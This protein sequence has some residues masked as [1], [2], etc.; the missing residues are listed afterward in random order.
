MDQQLSNS[1]TPVSPNDQE[2][3][4]PP[5]E[6]TRRGY[7]SQPQISQLLEQ[8]RDSRGDYRSLRHEIWGLAPA[9]PRVAEE[10]WVISI[11]AWAGLTEEESPSWTKQNPGARFLE[12]LIPDGTN[13]QRAKLIFERWVTVPNAYSAPWN[14]SFAVDS[15]DMMYQTTGENLREMFNSSDKI[16]GIIAQFSVSR[17]FDIIDL[18][19]AAAI[20]CL[21]RGNSRSLKGCPEFL[22]GHIA[23]WRERSVYD[24]CGMRELNVAEPDLAYRGRFKRLIYEERS[25]PMSAVFMHYMRSFVVTDF[26]EIGQ[27]SKPTIPGLNCLR[28]HLTF[29]GFYDGT[30]TKM[31]EKSYSTS[32][33]LL[34]LQGPAG[35]FALVSICDG[36]QSDVNRMF[37]GSPGGDTYSGHLSE[38][39]SRYGIYPAGL[40][41]GISMFQ[42]QLCVFID[43]WEQDWTS[44]IRHVDQMVSLNL[45]ILENDTHLRDLV[46]G[47]SNDDSVLYFKVLQFLNNFSDI[48]R[49]APSNLDT[50]WSNVREQGVVDDWFLDSY[51]HAE[52]L[53]T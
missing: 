24:R 7:D 14:K 19:N 15:I 52:K 35:H 41:T 42:L 34:P 33:N 53:I 37:R 11:N 5:S 18:N 17:L 16:C 49:A 10:L 46:L 3:P 36:Q 6:D 1:A 45:D 50:L 51:P 31:V 26:N 28:E 20:F 25:E 30:M 39:W 12:S 8:L 44:T 27:H 47:N 23:R 4:E 40:Y 21:V 22:D 2:L 13:L 38:L 32:L 29:R 9:I 48:V 43:S